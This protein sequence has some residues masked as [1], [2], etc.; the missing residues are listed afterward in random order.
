MQL[1]RHLK[2]SAQAPHASP[3]GGGLCY[4][5]PPV[6]QATQAPFVE[7]SQFVMAFLFKSFIKK[8][9]LR[10]LQIEN[11]SIILLSGN[12]AEGLFALRIS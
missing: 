2:W 8:T 5:N 11:K 12:I 10:L 7:L 3:G 4:V 1:F 9:L 6:K